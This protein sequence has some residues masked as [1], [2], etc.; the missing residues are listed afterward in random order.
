[1][2]IDSLNEFSDAQEVIVSM[3]STNVI[4]HGAA[5][6]AIG[7]EL[8]LHIL[9]DET[10]L[11]AGAAT[12]TFALRTDDNAS[13]TSPKTLWTSAA[14]GKATLVAGHVVA[15]VRVPKGLE[16]YSRLYYTVAT[17]PLTAGE[18][19]AFLSPSVQD[20]ALVTS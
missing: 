17:G 13:F 18:F 14:I 16:R 8:Y 19:N 20:Q 15:R 7:N 1:M 4:D 9:V 6:D 2:I 3:P 10:A 5:G 11:A 12:V